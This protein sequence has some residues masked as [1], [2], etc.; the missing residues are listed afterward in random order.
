MRLL[1]LLTFFL[2]LLSWMPKD[3]CYGCNKAFKDIS[4]HAAKCKKAHKFFEHGLRAWMDEQGERSRLREAKRQEKVEGKRV[5]VA[6][7]RARLVAR[8]VELEVHLSFFL[9][10]LRGSDHIYAG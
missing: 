2:C 6:E 3:V 10:V 5:K 1:W 7:A 8:Q 9:E 4:S